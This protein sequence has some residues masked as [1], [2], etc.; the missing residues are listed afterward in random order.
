MKKYRI[1]SEVA[2]GR[3]GE[4][5]DNNKKLTFKH[6]AEEFDTRKDAEKFI[7]ELIKDG[8]E[9]FMDGKYYDLETEK[10]IVPFYIEED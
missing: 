5:I 7:E 1:I 8:G 2:D 9:N 10:F 3:N 6:N 4:Y